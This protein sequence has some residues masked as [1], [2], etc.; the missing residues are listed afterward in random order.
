MVSHLV[1][2][3]DSE[4]KLKLATLRYPQ[5]G[6]YPIHTPENYRSLL[7][8]ATRQLAEPI[9]IFIHRSRS[10]QTL[11]RFPQ[12]NDKLSTIKDS[13]IKFQAIA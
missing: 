7:Y 3:W 12:H 11:P 10:I 1:S 13:I 5:A 2:I 6:P 8:P 4:S 9:A